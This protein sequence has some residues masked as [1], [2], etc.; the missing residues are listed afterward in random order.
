MPAAVSVNHRA[1]G[2]PSPDEP[3]DDGFYRRLRAEPARQPGEGA[4]HPPLI[5]AVIHDLLSPA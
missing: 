3:G 2:D 1:S 4:M 5:E